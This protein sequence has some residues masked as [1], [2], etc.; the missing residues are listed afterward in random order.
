MSGSF[1]RCRGLSPPTAR[2]LFRPHLPHPAYTSG[3]AGLLVV[4][5]A[6]RDQFF[7]V[8]SAGPE[9]RPE[10]TLV[11]TGWRVWERVRGASICTVCFRPGEESDG[12]W[13]HAGLLRAALEGA[14]LPLFA[15]AL[16]RWRSSGD[17]A[18]NDPPGFKDAMAR[19]ADAD[20]P[21]K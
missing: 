1:Q 16:S 10:R 11:I 9:Y 18:A 13:P 15:P 21:G 7:D 19:L 4:T 17:F 3:L 8:V 5:V 20:Q 2:W 6:G 12:G 14:G